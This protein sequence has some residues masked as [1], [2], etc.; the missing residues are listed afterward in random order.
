MFPDN[1]HLLLKAIEIAKEKREWNVVVKHCTKAEAVLYEDEKFNQVLLT[2]SIALQFCGKYK[3]AKDCFNFFM[4]N[5]QS[6]KGDGHRKFILFDNGDSRIE[7]YKYLGE[8]NGIILTF[9]SINLNWGRDP[10]GYKLLAKQNID[11][12]SLRRRKV[13][14]CHQDLT[15]DDY[16]KTVEK[17]VSGYEKKLAYG[18]S[19]GGYTSLYYASALNCEILALS[20][21]ISAHPIFGK[22]EYPRESFTHELT[23]PYNED[24]SPVIV[25]DPKDKRDNRF[26][27]E[28]IKR[29]FPRARYIRTN[30][31]GHA[32]APYLLKVGMLKTYVYCLL[33]GAE[34]PS[35]KRENNCLSPNYL[36]ILA[37]HCYRRGKLK[38]ALTLVD[39]ALAIEPHNKHGLKLRKNIQEKI[40]QDNKALLPA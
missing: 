10:F 29:A 20:P 40:K 2:K 28:N 25:Y 1:K 16:Y 39:R 7:F 36:R 19:L 30:Y 13:E 37:S 18:F 35:V 3:E 15:T 8:T 24:I 31:S 17:L 22:G 32:T 4:A 26:I 6:K 21:R 12:L 9:D 14:L 34:Y 33:N 23:F 27:E 11:I 5:N 38:W